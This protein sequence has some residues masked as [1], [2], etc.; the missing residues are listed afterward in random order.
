MDDW[1]D[2]LGVGLTELADPDDNLTEGQEPYCPIP[3]RVQPAPLW[4][5]RWRSYVFGDGNAPPEEYVTIS[6]TEYRLAGAAAYEITLLE[7][8]AWFDS[9]GAFPLPGALP[10]VQG[11]SGQ[12]RLRVLSGGFEAE[13]FHHGRQTLIVNAEYVFVDV[14]V[15][16]RAVLLESTPVAAQGAGESPAITVSKPQVRVIASPA[17]SRR[18]S[19]WRIADMIFV[20]TVSTFP[21]IRLAPG[22]SDVRVLGADRFGADVTLE[23]TGTAASPF[24][25]VTSGPIEEDWI[26]VDGSSHVGFSAIMGVG[27]TLVVEQRGW[28]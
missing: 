20:R 23:A 26:P 6:S 3:Q 2:G 24:T 4:A 9:A 16:V 25:T 22:V 19:E 1:S 21:P 8:V 5:Y 14:Q 7:E 13:R 17:R 27:G 10:L 11:V 12:A 15:P 28:I 18:P